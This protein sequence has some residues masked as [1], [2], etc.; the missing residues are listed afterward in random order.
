MNATTPS[1][2]PGDVQVDVPAPGLA[3]TK[4]ACHECRPEGHGVLAIEDGLVTE[5]KVHNDHGPDSSES[6]VKKT[7]QR[8]VQ[9]SRRKRKATND[10]GE[11]VKDSKGE[12]KEKNTRIRRM[13]RIRRSQR[14]RRYRHRKM[15]LW[16]CW[17]Q[18]MQKPKQRPTRKEMTRQ[19]KHQ[20]QPRT[21]RKRPRRRGRQ[22]RQLQRQRARRQRPK[23]QRARR[24]LRRW[25]L[26]RRNQRKARRQLLQIHSQKKFPSPAR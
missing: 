20:S 19:R 25:R 16:H 14:R 26:L 8:S 15:L 4:P 1:A 23:H 3:D 17:H 7:F 6:G 12:K 22:Q 24:R 5:T 2:I 9:E 21:R 11:N 10:P 13:R 18:S